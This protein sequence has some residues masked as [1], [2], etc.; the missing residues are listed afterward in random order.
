LPRLQSRPLLVQEA[1][2]VQS[3]LLLQPGPTT[4][5]D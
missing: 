5:V 1:L 3:L 4:M 2:E